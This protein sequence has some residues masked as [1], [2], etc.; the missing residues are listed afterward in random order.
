LFI[1]RYEGV[2]RRQSAPSRAI[3]ADLLPSSSS[4]SFLWYDNNDD[5]VVVVR[6]GGEP[7]SE[8]EITM[9]RTVRCESACAA[10]G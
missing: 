3:N 6:R 9:E 10:P 1:R 2:R 4:V 5:V 8:L 7:R